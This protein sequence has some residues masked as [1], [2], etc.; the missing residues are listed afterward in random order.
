[1]TKKFPLIAPEAQTVI[2]ILII[3]IIG[4]FSMGFSVIGLVLGAILGVIL[5][6]YRDLPRNIPPAPLG[7]VSPVDGVV[8]RVEKVQD[9]YLDR[10]M[11]RIA[12][13]MSILGGY[14]LRAPIEGKL[15]K[16]WFPGSE[17][18][19][20]VNGEAYTQWIQTDEEDDVLLLITLKGSLHQPRCYVHP[21]E[22]VGQGQ[23][24]GFVHFGAPI[25]V[26]VPANSRIEAKEG[27]KLRAGSDIIASLVHNN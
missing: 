22:R 2:I 14:A 26:L 7:V 8:T 4:V 27:D 19:K 9:V 5:Y 25:E 24:C 18:A 15:V 16:Q 1:M 10:E 23:R 21:G 20:G 17:T 13:N 12:M 11:I 6:L 3:V